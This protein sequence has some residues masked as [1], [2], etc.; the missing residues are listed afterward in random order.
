MGLK[1]F[2]NY[3]IGFL[4]I[5]VEIINIKI[6]I[7]LKFVVMFKLFVGGWKLKSFIRFMFN[8]NKNRVFKYGE[9]IC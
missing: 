2:K 6:D 5:I 1:W 8:R 3:F 9:K 4:S 7:I